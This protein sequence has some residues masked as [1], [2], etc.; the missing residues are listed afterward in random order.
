MFT[1]ITARKTLFLLT[2]ALWI[3]G[4]GH[5]QDYNVNALLSDRTARP[6]GGGKFAPLNPSV[7]GDSVV[8]NQ[9][10]VCAGCAAPDSLWSVNTTSGELRKLAPAGGVAF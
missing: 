4:V 2:Q 7:D 10:D 1:Q 5:S 8:F 9:G 3:A 6:D